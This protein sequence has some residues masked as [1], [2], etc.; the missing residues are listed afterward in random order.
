MLDL[1]EREV[2]IGGGPSARRSVL[3]QDLSFLLLTV[4]GGRGHREDRDYPDVPKNWGFMTL[5]RNKKK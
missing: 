2:C 1:G 3:K 5:R 4:I